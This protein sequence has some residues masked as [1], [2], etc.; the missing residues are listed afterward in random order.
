[1]GST[2]E[3]ITLQFN[4]DTPILELPCIC[5][6]SLY[7]YGSE[8]NYQRFCHSYFITNIYDPNE[9]IIY[10]HIITDVKYKPDSV[11]S[12]CDGYFGKCW[13]VTINDVENDK[14]EK[15]YIRNWIDIVEYYKEKGIK[16]V[17][18]K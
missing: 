15:Y 4:N 3:G 6:P 5:R 11:Y 2:L 8:S 16:F 10:K 9:D 14:I 18:E 7:H 1:M 12:T 13:V 17:E